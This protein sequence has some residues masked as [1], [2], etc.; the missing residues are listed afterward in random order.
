MVD[1]IIDDGR[2]I[3]ERSKTNQ[4]PDIHALFEGFKGKY[5]PSEIDWGDP[6]GREVW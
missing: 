4:R 3:I 6:S 2:I 5:E 1:I